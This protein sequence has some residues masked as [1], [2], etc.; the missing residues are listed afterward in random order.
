MS[1]TRYTPKDVAINLATRKSVTSVWWAE[2]ESH[3]LSDETLPSSIKS[4]RD[5]ISL[6][7]YNQQ[8]DGWEFKRLELYDKLFKERMKKFSDMIAKNWIKKETVQLNDKILPIPIQALIIKYSASYRF[9]NKIEYDNL[10]Y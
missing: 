7:E 6:D 5:G 3:S 9:T 10:R 8:L 2:L 4:I 1:D